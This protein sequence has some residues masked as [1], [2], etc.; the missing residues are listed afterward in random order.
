M[1]LMEGV[2]TLQQMMDMLNDQN[3]AALV[4]LRIG[5]WLLCCLSVYMTLYPLFAFFDIL[6]D[7]IE[8]IPCVGDFIAGMVDTV[9]GCALCCFAFAF[10]TSVSLLD[11]SIAWLFVRPWVGVPLFLAS[12]A[13]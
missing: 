13:I 2:Q 1:N 8:C 10:G 6:S 7:Y 3:Y 12:L 9:V 5:F 4:A 11:I